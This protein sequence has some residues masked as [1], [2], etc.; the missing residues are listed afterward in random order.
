M[1]RALILHASIR[2]LA[3][4]AVAAVALVGRA[5]DDGW[6]PFEEAKPAAEAHRWVIPPDQFEGWVFQNAR[7]AQGQ[8]KQFQAKLKLALDNIDKS[9]SLSEA[10]REKLRLTGELQIER[11]FE[12]YERVRRTYIQTKPGP[13]DFNVIWQ[14]IQPLQQ[15]AQSGIFTNDSLLLKVLRGVLDD[16]QQAQHKRDEKARRAFRYRALVEVFVLLIDESA[17]MT[18]QQRRDLIEL[19]LTQTKPPSAFGQQDQYYMMYQLHTVPAEK[20]R[21]VVGGAQ[22]DLLTKI[23]ATGRAYEAHLRAQGVHPVE[24]D[25]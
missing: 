15:E 6:E 17:P 4:A 21:K 2:P 10:Q 1:N 23:G 18:D 13:N 20:L 5:D 11:Y 19:L 12:K 3:L 24:E 16:S 14:E 22:G 8:R 9:C 25:Q 7:T